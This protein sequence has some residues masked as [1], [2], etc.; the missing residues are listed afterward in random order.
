MSFESRL[1]NAGKISQENT[2]TAMK[3]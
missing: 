2:T 1:D 3:L